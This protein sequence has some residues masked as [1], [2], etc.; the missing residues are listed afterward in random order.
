M[1]I[2][3]V[4]SVFT[5]TMKGQLSASHMAKELQILDKLISDIKWDT[6]SNYLLYHNIAYSAADIEDN[7]NIEIWMIDLSC[8]NC[9]ASEELNELLCVQEFEYDYPV[10]DWMLEVSGITAQNDT[11]YEKEDS[12]PVENWMYDLTKFKGIN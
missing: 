9:E 6:Y 4:A 5:F 12:Y 8:W 2:L 10:E 1:L 11:Q 7:Q 3:L